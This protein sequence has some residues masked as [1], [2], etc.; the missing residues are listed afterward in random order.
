M[1][2]ES[3]FVLRRGILA[4]SERAGSM[5]QRYCVHMTRTLLLVASSILAAAC[6]ATDER[7]SSAAV[8]T[9]VA[10]PPIPSARQLAWHRIELAAFFHFGVNTFTDREWGVGTEDPAIFA[11][12]DID[13]KQWARTLPTTPALCTMADLAAHRCAG[14]P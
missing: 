14:V 7:P 12:T 8:D 11:P 4:V 3:T 2:A 6:S 9:L 13:A 5:S 10:C 1:S